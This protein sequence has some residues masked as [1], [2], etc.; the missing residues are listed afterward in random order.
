MDVIDDILLLILER[1]VSRLPRRTCKR[2]HG[3]IADAGFLHRYRSAH[4]PSL[5]TGHYFNGILYETDSKS[6]VRLSFVPRLKDRP[7]TSFVPA[8]TAASSPIA[9]RNFSSLDFLP[10]DGDDCPPTWAVLD[11]RGSL[12]LLY[13]MASGQSFDGVSVQNFGEILRNSVISPPSEI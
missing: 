5:V 1:I 8:G 4:A 12:L 7:S 9:A 2:W 6:K 11:S 13:C 10:G 3:I